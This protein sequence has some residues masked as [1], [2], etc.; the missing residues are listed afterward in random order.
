MSSEGPRLRNPFASAQFSDLATHTFERYAKA[1]QGASVGA[2]SAVS[3]TQLRMPVSVVS[4]A[5][6]TLYAEV[7]QTVVVVA[8]FS[9]SP[10]AR[11]VPWPRS[12]IVV[13][14]VCFC[15]VRVVGAPI[16]SAAGCL[17]F[18]DLIPAL[19][20]KLVPPTELL[21]LTA[22]A[23]VLKGQSSIVR[24]AGS[25]VTTSFDS[26]VM[27]PIIAAAEEDVMPFIRLAPGLSLQDFVAVAQLVFAEAAAF[28]A[29]VGG[30]L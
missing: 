5:V 26:Q 30:G 6:H 20:V 27:N 23:L 17:A 21:C 13:S 14:E 18:Q 9:A 16:T 4:Q 22:L 3:A 2:A 11:T 29:T 25:D 7:R 1:V 24:E 28:R 15:G 19:R 10:I 8:P 12:W